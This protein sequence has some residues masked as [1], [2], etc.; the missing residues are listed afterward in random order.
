[1]A[2]VVL[3][4]AIAGFVGFLPLWAALKLMQRSADV[5]MLSTAAK[6]L[7]GVF[8]SLVLLACAM[9]A[10]SVF[11]HDYVGVFGAVELVAFVVFSVAYFMR[12]NKVLKRKAQDERE[13][14]GE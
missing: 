4:G 3:M 12:R 1:M 14:E 8:V 7:G 6:S 13:S 11:A 9:L 10:C 5:G 2:L